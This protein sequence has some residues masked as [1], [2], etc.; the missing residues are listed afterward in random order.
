MTIMVHHVNQRAV[1]K[2]MP[3][4]IDGQF[5]MERIMDFRSKC[6][7][8]SAPGG[9]GS[10]TPKG[11]RRIQIDGRKWFEHVLVWVHLVGPIPDGKQLH[12]KNGDKLD[13]RIENLE[14]LDPKTHK[15]KHSGCILAANGEWWKPCRKCKTFFPISSYYSRIDGDCV[16]SW[17]R[18][19][20]IK[21]TVE[22]KRRRRMEKRYAETSISLGQ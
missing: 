11:Y 6:M 22:N 18:E 14:C 12:H 15:H 21:N 9:Y 5:S 20:C 13:N 7:P 10:I 19:C 8:S 17:C 16:R 4:F 3:R 1:L 2:T